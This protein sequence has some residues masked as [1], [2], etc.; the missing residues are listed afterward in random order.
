MTCEFKSD[1]T[2]VVSAAFGGK[3]STDIGIWATEGNK[4]TYTGTW[5]TEGNKLTMKVIMDGETP[6]ERYIYSK[7]WSANYDF[8]LSC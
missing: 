8:R 1:Q 5:T 2:V 6:S 3:S 7:K 4:L